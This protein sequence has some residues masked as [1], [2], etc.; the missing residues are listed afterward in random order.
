MHIPLLALL[1]SLSPTLLLAAEADTGQ[2][3]A[4]EA[5]EVEDILAAEEAA[6]AEE[7]KSGT[8]PDASANTAN[9]EPVREAG[10]VAP[11]ESGEDFVPTVQ[12]SEDLSVSFPV[13]I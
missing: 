5:K 9:A 2:L 12:I 1:L 11:K 3:S 8:T 6:R 7:A 13:N 10:A 4:S